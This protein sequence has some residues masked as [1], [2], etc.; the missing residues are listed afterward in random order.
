MSDIVFM[1]VIF[2]NILETT[3]VVSNV[4]IHSQLQLFRFMLST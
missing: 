3:F 4:L 1:G 2:W